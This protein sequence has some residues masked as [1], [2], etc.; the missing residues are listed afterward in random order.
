MARPSAKK[1][2]AEVQIVEMK[3]QGLNAAQMRK[4]IEDTGLLNKVQL[5]DLLPQTVAPEKPKP[6]EEAPKQDLKAHKENL[7]EL[8]LG[9]EHCWKILATVDRPDEK[10]ARAS[11]IILVR[12]LKGYAD[13]I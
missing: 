9:L 1:A 5:D 11:L 4:K 12:K 6:I 2:A 10:N 8:G 13:A 3:E 7:I